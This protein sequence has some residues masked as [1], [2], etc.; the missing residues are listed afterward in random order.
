MD[1][2]INNVIGKKVLIIGDIMLD[3]YVWGDVKRISPEA[4][5]PILNKK[6][7]AYKLGG[8]SN[9]AL[10][11]KALQGEPTIISIIGDDDSGKKMKELLFENN[12]TNFLI[13]T[14]KPTTEK[15]RLLSGN[16][17]LLRIDT[18]DTTYIN[19]FYENELYQVIANEIPN[20]AVIILSDYNKGVLT[21]RLIKAI[22]DLAKENNKPVIVD[23]KVKNFFNYKGVDVFK[24]NLKEINDAFKNEKDDNYKDVTK[25]LKN[26]IGAKNIMVTLSEKGIY[27]LGEYTDHEVSG[28]N[29]ELADT[30]GAGDTVVSVLALF[31]GEIDNDKLLEVC[32]IAGSMVC[33]HVGVVQI[34]LD[35]LKKRF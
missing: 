34:T 30:C 20:T 29:V 27:M 8:A 16:H 5:V 22:I 7:E 10:N 25:L 12:I 1:K 31:Y 35:K 2:I 23:P 18:E 9:V 3:S 13:T 33:E 6:D 28:I 15:K 17:H 21:E 32:N 19:S 4:P 14:P 24:P 11:I 26:V